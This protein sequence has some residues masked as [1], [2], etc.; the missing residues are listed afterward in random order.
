[1][2]KGFMGKSHALISVMLLCICMLIPVNVFKETVGLLKT[3]IPFFIVGILVLS[4]S[5]LLPDL[6]NGVSSA[7]SSLGFFGGMCT[8]FMQTTSSLFWTLFHTK[9][10][11]TPESPH[12]YFWHTGIVGI[13]LICLFW[14][15]MPKGAFTMI[16]DIQN[17]SI[18]EYL[19]KHIIVIFFLFFVFMAILCGS[20]M[21]IGKLLQAF[22]LPK[23]LNY[24]CP[25]LVLFYVMSIDYTHMRIL[26]ICIGLGYFFHCVEDLFADTGVAG[27][28]FPIPIK[29]RFWA[30]VKI[31]K[32]CTTGGLFNTILDIV[33]LTVDI[34]LMALIFVK[35]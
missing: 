25:V 19:Q 34:G 32:T 12:R 23:V 3:N 6:D 14:F 35:G 5:A 30:R 16:E 24:F 13:G 26:G 20:D 10:D 22:G 18:V 4:G 29:R 27:F 31:P 8:V 7:N 21:I 28:F 2:V 15:V 17:T 9:G 11:K 33:I 1:M